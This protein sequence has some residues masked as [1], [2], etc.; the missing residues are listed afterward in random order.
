[1]PCTLIKTSVKPDGVEWY[2]TSNA[3]EVNQLVEATRTFPGV[4]SH[5]SSK[6]PGT[7]NFW[8]SVTVFSD[9]AACNS[10]RKAMSATPEYKKRQAYN[11]QHGIVV[12]RKIVE[13]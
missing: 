11:Q 1:M 6:I 12:E 5:T 10:F 3:A 2:N 4:V 13:S 8:R 9:R 7:A